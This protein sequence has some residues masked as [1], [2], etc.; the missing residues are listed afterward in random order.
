[1]EPR[2]EGSPTD[3]EEFSFSRG[4]PSNA[5][6]TTLNTDQI[7]WLLKQLSTDDSKKLGEELKGCT[8]EM[9][10]TRGLPF[11]VAIMGSLW[12]AR[13]RLPAKFHFGP[14]GPW[15]Y[16]I[17]GIASL[18]AANFMA[19][20]TCSDRMK[21]RLRELWIKYSSV[22]NK[23]ST[24]ATTYEMLRQRNRANLTGAPEV[25]P[26]SSE[27]ILAA[28]EGQ[29]SSD[30]P[31]LQR[32]ALASSSPGF[33]YDKEPSLMSGTPVDSPSRQPSQSNEKTNQYGDVGFS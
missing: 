27:A 21:P 12:F 29:P 20:G 1:M 31:S 7:Q 17:M 26:S 14:K 10:I 16:P 15:F 30:H 28:S 9:V 19:I 23:K 3:G 13:N 33:L 22:D 8:S 25:G 6:G 18:T 4:S 32:G 11:S 5:S 2:R 24:S